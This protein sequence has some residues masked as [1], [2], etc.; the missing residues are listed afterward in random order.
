[1]AHKT[2]PLCIVCTVL[3]ALSNLEN[4]GGWHSF[5]SPRKSA[6]SL[7]VRQ[8]SR[9]DLPTYEESAIMIPFGK[10]VVRTNTIFNLLKW[11]FLTYLPKES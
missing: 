2:F 6:R 5:P 4:R 1:M 10:Y 9:A 8:F 7:V 3:Q 11:I